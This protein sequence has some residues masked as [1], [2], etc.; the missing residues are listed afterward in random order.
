MRTT[1]CLLILVLTAAFSAPAGAA[2]F[3]QLTPGDG[4]DKIQFQ[5][6][7]MNDAG[8]FVAV[9]HSN[10]YVGDATAGKLTR[11]LANDRLGFVLED[12]ETATVANTSVRMDL[13]LLG[14]RLAI[15]GRGDYVL[16]SHTTLLVGNAAGGEPRKVHEEPN[17]TFQQVALNDAGQYVALTRRGILVGSVADAAAKRVAS[18]SPGSFESFSVGGLNGNWDAEVG[19]TRLA[20]NARGQFVAASGRAFYGGSVPEAVATKL[21]ENAKVGFRQVRLA[22]DGTFTA[23]SARNVYRGKL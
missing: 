19:Q 8:Q 16:A 18:E 2:T 1:T 6:L 13:A 11:V 7:A 17:T 22:A 3:D 23:V 4:I 15:N 21:Y 9:S 20:L 10:V 5:H 12:S 14:T